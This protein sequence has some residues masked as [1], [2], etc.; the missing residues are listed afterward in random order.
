MN[1]TTYPWEAGEGKDKNLLF[2]IQY[3][4]IL[5]FPIFFLL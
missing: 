1:M 2:G 4:K 5:N 3:Q